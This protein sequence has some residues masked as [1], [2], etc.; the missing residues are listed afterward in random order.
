MPGDLASRIDTYAEMVDALPR[1]EEAAEVVNL[2][3]TREL[4]Q[5]RLTQQGDPVAPTILETLHRADSRLREH[6]LMLA[7]RFPEIFESREALP[8]EYWWWHLEV[9]PPI[10]RRAHAS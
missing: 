7:E 3:V 9:H 6:G 5:D 2:F 4:I 10:G 8:R 1:Y